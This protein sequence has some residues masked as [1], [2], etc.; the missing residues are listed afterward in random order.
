MISVVELIISDASHFTRRAM[1]CSHAAD[2]PS[3]RHAAQERR[4]QDTDRHPRG[5]KVRYNTHL[6]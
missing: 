3:A 1:G 5:L 2:W 4:P 6:E